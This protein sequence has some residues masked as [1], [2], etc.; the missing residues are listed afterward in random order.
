MLIWFVSAGAIRIALSATLTTAQP[1]IASQAVI[2]ALTGAVCAH[3]PRGGATRR[4]RQQS[5]ITRRTSARLCW[6]GPGSG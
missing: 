6:A 2:D 3:C 5:R 4:Q 1:A